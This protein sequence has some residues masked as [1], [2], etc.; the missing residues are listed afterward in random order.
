MISD[1]PYM[2]EQWDFDKNDDDITKTSAKLKDTRHWKCKICEYTWQ[3]S[4][5]ARYISSGL[6][7]CHESNKAIRKGVNDLFTVVPELESIY[8]F[9]ANTDIDIYSEGVD[10]A[11]RPHWRC[12]E[13]G[14]K[15]QTSIKSRTKVVDGKRVAILCPHYN[16]VKRTKDEVPYV[17]E[18]PEL[19]K[20]WDYENNTLDPTITKSNSTKRANF[21]CPNCTY[22]WPAEIRSQLRGTGKCKCCELNQVIMPGINDLFTLV[23]DARLDIDFNENPGIDFEHLGTRSQTKI[24]WTCHKCGNKRNRPVNSLINGNSTD[25]YQLRKCQ[26]CYRH[27]VNRI[28]PVSS[29]PHLVKFW[30][31]EKNTDKDINLTSAYSTEDAYW[32]CPKCGYSWPTMIKSRNINDFCPCCNSGRAIHKGVN[33]ILSLVPEFANIYNFE[34]NKDIDIYKLSPN[35]TEKVWITC[36]GCKV[37]RK[38]SV[39]RLVTKENGKYKLADCVYCAKTRVLANFNSLAAVAPDIAK[40]WSP[41]NKRLAD[42]YFPTAEDWVAWICSDCGE[43]FNARINEMVLGTASCPF[44]NYRLLLPKVNSLK[45]VY[46]NIA[47]MWSPNNKKQPD[48]VLPNW[49]M[50]VKWICTDCDG[51]YMAPIS[52]MVEGV[53]ECPF[54][55]GKRVNPKTNSLAALYPDIAAM[56]APDNIYHSDR[57]SP[58][59]ATSAKWICPDCS[60]KYY[61]LVNEMVSGETD[62]PYCN[63][64][65]VLPGFNSLARKHKE[66]A[67]LWS[68]N[69]PKSADEVLPNVTVLA[70]WIC[71]DCSGEYNAPINEMTDGTYTC[72]YCTDRMVLKDY[73]SLYVRFPDVAKKWSPNNDKTAFEVLPT[74]SVPAKWICPDCTGEYNAPIN[75]MTDGTYTCPYCEDRMVLPGVN[76]FKVKHPDLMAE[77]DFQNNYVLANADHISDHSIKLVWWQCPNNDKHKYPMTPARRL[78]YQK[79]HKESC[80]YCKGLRRKRK[81][82]I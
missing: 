53:V 59:S 12:L 18:V 80:P 19:I 6:C 35:S 26:Q 8:D 70:K 13:C 72:P 55:A 48:E 24:N 11:K 25:G 47:N 73:N 44:C 20:F 16:T 30:D 63:G 60:G 81:H 82:F 78:H 67:K 32:L 56:W 41:N 22:S 42:T 7:P 69:N 66:I 76:S 52:D 37:T 31:F 58:T 34:K 23:P 68:P 39:R 27:D 65:M 10:S 21:K 33:D 3:A 29:V 77:W 14:R 28:T 75:E 1:I 45:V 43:D 62:C 71:P 17:S 46:P 50:A 2:V 79:R 64:R 51:E 9:E 49:A 36:P 74:V 38:K 40:M 57:V 15:W 5:V 54:C 4:P 61:S